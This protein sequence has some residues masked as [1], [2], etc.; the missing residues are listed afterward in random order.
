MFRIVRNYDSL[1]VCG[2]QSN[3]G[4]AFGRDVVL[5]RAQGVKSR[6]IRC[7]VRKTILV[8]LDGQSILHDAIFNSFTFFPS[9]SYTSCFTTGP[10]TKLLSAHV[11]VP[12]YFVR[13]LLRTQTYDFG[14]NS[15]ARFVFHQSRNLFVH[16]RQPGRMVLGIC[17]RVEHRGNVFANVF[18]EVFGVNFVYERIGG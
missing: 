16:S 15:P 8:M 4:Y 18:K 9:V 11:V 17:R 7:V 6:T 2:G 14:Y 12:I 3:F 5:S 1:V 13:V 10:I